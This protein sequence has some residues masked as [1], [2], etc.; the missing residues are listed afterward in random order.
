M[1]VGS[2]FMLILLLLF[3]WFDSSLS[4]WCDSWRT[5]VKY[6]ISFVSMVVSAFI[7]MNT[8]LLYLHFCLTWLA[9]SINESIHYLH[10]VWYSVVLALITRDGKE[11]NE[12]FGFRSHYLSYDNPRVLLFLCFHSPFRL[13]YVARMIGT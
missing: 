11:Y 3:Q 12:P 13:V 2:I 6:L 1:V 8:D 9:Q 4:N 7:P 5:L 10:R